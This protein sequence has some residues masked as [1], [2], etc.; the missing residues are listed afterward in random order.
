MHERD[1]VAVIGA[2]AW[3]TALAHVLARAGRRVTLWAR[4]P[5]VAR[6]IGDTRENATLLPGVRLAPQL[7]CTADLDAAL[8]AEIAILAVPTQFLA[9]VLAQARAPAPPRQTLV[10]TA[11]GLERRTHRLVGEVVAELR[12]HAR[13]AVL[14]G[15]S[16]AHDVAREL[17]TAV[18]LAAARLDE[19][20]VLAAALA[21]RAL[22]IYASDDPRGVQI[23]GALKNVVA[24]ACGIVIGRGLGESA[25]AAL[26]TRGLAEMARLSEALGGRRATMMG[27]S[28]LGD[29]ALTC[30]SP[31]SR[32][33]AL[34]QALGAGARLADLLD[35]RR[36]VVEG[37]ATAAAVS[38]L[39]AERGI[40]MPIA[41]AVDAVLHRGADLDA[42]IA[43][44]MSRPL[45][46][47]A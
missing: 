47:E 10:I 2:G 45:K 29:L 38:E 16:F 36:S 26:L 37:V 21:T 25:R 13:L 28:G 34:G 44:L 20:R 24:I 35:A 17:P 46:E 3:G 4:R 11:K 9:G 43:G 6:E 32:N 31:Q 23:G 40:D 14:S 8:G 30:A 42:T 19:A 33:F 41:A 18:V 39:A 12:P 15:P 22:R 5:E 27:L 7:I 1:G